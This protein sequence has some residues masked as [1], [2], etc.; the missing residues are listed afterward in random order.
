MPRWD[1]QGNLIQEKP[2]RWDASGKP[3]RALTYEEAL[4]AGGKPIDEG[5]ERGWL[6]KAWDWAN[7]GVISKDTLVQVISGKTTEQLN[8][9]LQDYSG[10][11]P[12]HAAIR[13]FVRGTIQST[14]Q[15]ASGFISPLAVATM[16]AGLATKIPGALGVI[17]KAASGGAATG[18]G[19]MGVKAALEQGPAGE[20]F[21]EEVERRLG[22][23]AMAAGGAAGLGATGIPAA[24][25]P[26]FIAQGKQLGALGKNVGKVIVARP[27]TV[28]YDWAKGS[29]ELL[30]KA[31]AEDHAVKVAAYPKIKP[32]FNGPQVEAILPADHHL[33]GIRA[34]REKLDVAGLTEKGVRD[35]RAELWTYRKRLALPSDEFKAYGD[36][37]AKLT[38][39]LRGQYEQAGKLQEFLDAE[40]GFSQY[41]ETFRHPDS[42][43]YKALEEEFPAT[44]FVEPAAVF[45]KLGTVVA[46]KQLESLGV[47]LGLGELFRVRQVSKFSDPAFSSGIAFTFKIPII[48]QALEYLLTRPVGIRALKT[49]KPTPVAIQ[50]QMNL[51]GTAMTGPLFESPP[52]SPAAPGLSKEFW[53]GQGEA[54]F[55]PPPRINLR[56]NPAAMTAEEAPGWSGPKSVEAINEALLQG[57]ESLKAALEREFQ[58][59]KGQVKARESLKAALERGFQK[60]KA[61]AGQVKARKAKAA[62][63][64]AAR[65]AA[66]FQQ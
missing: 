47:K 12:V 32:E 64:A 9:E 30:K 33:A 10:E 1:A 53:E 56:E 6:G 60:K 27:G 55:Q 19:G 66:R 5:S 38:D 49:P 20:T 51:G 61:I 41:M 39:Q 65:R 50:K 42:P 28:E 3:L 31:R 26:K 34:A 17:A 21:P 63:E 54:G 11:S 22:G 4:T 62:A 16:G 14:G 25:L 58:K 15:V 2:K 37:Y 23:A 40:K 13:E 52:P 44:G 45:K 29:L 43:A 35:A 8:E 24:A 59:K 46:K 18:F 57:K 36:A 48:R 7:Q